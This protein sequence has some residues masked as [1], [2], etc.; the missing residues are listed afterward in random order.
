MENI[1]QLKYPIG[2]FVKPDTIDELLIRQWINDIQQFPALLEELTAPLTVA[3]LNWRYRPE[4]WTIKQVAHHCADSHINSLIRFKLA[5]TEDA[6]TIR[7]YFEGRWATLPDSMDDD[8]SSTMFLL[9]GLHQK[10]VKLLRNLSEEELD[11]TFVHPEYGK[12]YTL[13]ENIGIYAWHGNHHLAHIW[14][15]LQKK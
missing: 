6:P 3:Q 5:L 1:E 10:W 4:G 11:K 8:L 13:R 12:V 9:K 7:P 2:K 14:Q 15:A